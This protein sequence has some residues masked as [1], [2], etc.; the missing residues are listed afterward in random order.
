[1]N[2][3]IIAREEGEMVRGERA[4]MEACTLVNK[5]GRD[6]ATVV[7]IPARVIQTSKK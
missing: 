4:T 6:G 7:G 1:M 2:S 3:S 5:S